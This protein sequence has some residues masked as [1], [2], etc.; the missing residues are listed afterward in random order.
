[1]TRQKN[2]TLGSVNT[3]RRIKFP[4]RH[5]YSPRTWLRNQPIPP[6]RKIS[7]VS[8]LI[9]N[10]VN[11]L[12]KD[13]HTFGGITIVYAIGV[14]IFVRS[15]S[16]GSSTAAVASSSG[17]GAKLSGAVSQIASLMTS[18]N[19]SLSAASSV[20]QIIISTICCLALI[21]A[22]R[23]VLS[24]EKASAKQSFYQGMTP[25]VK[26]LLVLVMFG[27]Q[28]IPI[29][30]GGYIFSLLVSSKVFLGWELGIAALVFILLAIWS[31]YLVTHSVFALFITTLPDMTPIKALRSAKKMVYKRRLLILRKVLGAVIVV[32]IVAILLMAPF[33]L[34]WAAAAPWAVYLLSVV[35]VPISQ[36]Y[37]YTIYREIL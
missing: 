10:S 5:W 26:Y 11:L 27:L 12:R 31:L 32:S 6:R 29:A 20:Y 16:I 14:L 18:A 24:N 8:Q 25:L 33:V 19:A 15:F 37:L 22:F 13:W 3:D 21:W 2:D 35:I 4:K 1:M 36:A 7:S 9:K 17:I 28:L 23:Q 34:W 30:V